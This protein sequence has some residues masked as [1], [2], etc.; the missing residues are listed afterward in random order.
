[1]P[2]RKS[3]T[4]IDEICRVEVF[5]AWITTP[6]NRDSGLAAQQCGYI[7]TIDPIFVI[8]NSP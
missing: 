6:E 4:A 7:E 1:M 8:A 2:Q 3:G 5:G